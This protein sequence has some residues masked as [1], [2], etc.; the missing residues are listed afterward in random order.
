[1]KECPDYTCPGTGC[2][3]DGV[4]YKCSSCKDIG[5]DP[6]TGCIQC[7]NYFSPES[8]CTQCL[9]NYSVS[10][11]CAECEENYLKVEIEEIFKCFLICD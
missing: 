6:E 10:S 8:F 1:M 7:L 5:K 11:N 9:Y 3:I 2:Y 4:E